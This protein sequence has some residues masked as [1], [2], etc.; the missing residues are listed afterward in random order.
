MG[1]CW[2]YPEWNFVTQFGPITAAEAKLATVQLTVKDYDSVSSDDT[3]GTVDVSCPT[4]ARGAPCAASVAFGTE[5]I[6]TYE[7]S[8]WQDYS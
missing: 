6:V 4:V 5:G 3:L 1:T 8:L 7:V 2:G